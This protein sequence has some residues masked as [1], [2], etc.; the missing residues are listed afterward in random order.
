[1]LTYVYHK[2]SGKKRITAHPVLKVEEREKRT[3]V[4][5]RVFKSGD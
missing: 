4:I 5:V 1:M 2:S 3:Y